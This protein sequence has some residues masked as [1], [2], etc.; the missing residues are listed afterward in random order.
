MYTIYGHTVT[1]TNKTSFIWFVPVYCLLIAGAYILSSSCFPA[2]VEG[3]K[4]FGF[5]LSKAEKFNSTLFIHLLTGVLFIALAHILSGL[6]NVCISKGNILLA[7]LLILN[8]YC[9]GAGINVALLHTT[10]FWVIKENLSLIQVLQNLRIK[11]ELQLYWVMFLFTFIIPVLKIITMAYDIFISKGDGRKNILLSVLSKWGMLDILVV[12]III[13]TMKSGSGFAEMTTG[14]GLTFFIA[15]V[16]I[17]M[18]ISMCMPYTK[19]K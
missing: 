17:S 4:I 15:S 11:G 3:D 19:N 8:I 2:I 18:V 6:L 1:Q 12:G 7:I 14:Y 9:F 13:S 5:A 10:K 16:V